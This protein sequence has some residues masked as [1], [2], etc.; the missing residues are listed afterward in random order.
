MEIIKTLVEEFLFDEERLLL[1]LYYNKVIQRNISNTYKEFKTQPNISN[2]LKR[3]FK[4]LKF[5]YQWKHLRVET[6]IKIMNKYEYELDENKTKIKKFKSW[7]QEKKDWKNILIYFFYG[8]NFT[9]ISKILK[10]SS[11]ELVRYRIKNYLKILNDKPEFGPFIKYFKNIEFKK[12]NK[13]SN[14]YSK[15]RFN[16]EIYKRKIDKNILMFNKTVR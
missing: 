8:Y 11:Y 15:K 6:L 2:K 14:P 1:F 12:N 3:I 7:T 9:E 4:K 5:L 10:I 13:N 16:R